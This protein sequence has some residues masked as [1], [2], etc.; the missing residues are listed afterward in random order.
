MK[1]QT[2]WDDLNDIS[3]GEFIKA[4]S[5]KSNTHTSLTM[6]LQFFAKS[7]PTYDIN[8]LVK[9]QARV[10][11]NVVQSMKRNISEEGIN[12]VPPIEIRVHEGEALIVQGHH[13]LE[14]YKQLGY[15][16]VPIKYVRSSQLGKNQKNGDYYRELQELLD[17]RI[18]N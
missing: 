6:N 17:G 2:D 8:K 1:V 9:T 15:E 10:D 14:A 12:A 5:A 4:G 13:R 7:T 18:Y 11:P 16:R 3:L